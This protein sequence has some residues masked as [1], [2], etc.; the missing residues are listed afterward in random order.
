MHAA[1][2][3]AKA[4]VAAPHVT[5]WGWFWI[6]WVLAAAGVEFY[7]LAVNTANTLSREIWGIEKIDLAHPLMFSEWTPAHYAI[8]IV[9]W[10]FF[11]WLSVHF[12]FGWIR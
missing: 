1:L 6:A 10:L 4:A 11:G 12:V 7:W 8:A 2:R 3:A 9:L 5:G